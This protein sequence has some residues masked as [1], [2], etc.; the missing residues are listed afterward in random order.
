MWHLLLNAVL[1]IM[2][3][4]NKD[5]ICN[6][7]SAPFGAPGST[8]QRETSER[9]EPQVSMTTGR[10]AHTLPDH[11]HIYLHTPLAIFGPHL[12]H[13][14]NS[15]HP[16]SVSSPTF[17]DIASPPGQWPPYLDVRPPAWPLHLDVSQASQEEQV[18]G[19]TAS[20]LSVV[21]LSPA[22]SSAS[23]VDGPTTHQV[24]SRGDPTLVETLV[25]SPVPTV[26]CLF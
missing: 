21:T 3:A 13:H 4:L 23:S 5:P 18:Y 17:R 2:D 9:G 19:G 11:P 10:T 25:C 7:S 16:L 22:C 12:A 20:A 6:G 1:G 8:S 26:T 14:P 24:I 15:H